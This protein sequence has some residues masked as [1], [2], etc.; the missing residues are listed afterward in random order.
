MLRPPLKDGGISLEKAI[1]LRR[2]VRSFR[3]RAITM[4]QFSQLLWSGQGIT[5]DG[6]FKRSAPS[7][8]ALYP[9][10]IYTCL[11]DECV[12]GLSAGVYHYIPASHSIEKVNEGDSRGDLAG[13]S[14]GQMWMAK[15]PVSFILTAQYSRITGKYGDRGIRYALIEI[16]HIGQNIFLQC[17]ALGLSAGI[18]GAF[19]DRE[20]AKVLGLKK[21][22]SPLI[23]MPVGWA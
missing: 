13:A 11:G 14:L 3:D 9:A 5:E 16:G 20:V 8:G 22:H 15:A 6:G 7:G 12:A 23:V 10:D 21:D 17:Q 1:S 2:T 4:E 19:D 18:V